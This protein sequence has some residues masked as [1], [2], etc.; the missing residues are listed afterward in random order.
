MLHD[1]K[2]EGDR[3]NLV[4]LQ[5]QDIELIRNWRNKDEIRKWF[6]NDSIISKEAQKNWFA[7][8]SSKEKDYV[9]L[10]EE[11]TGKKI[12]MLAIYNFSNNG[13]MVE[14]GRF[15]IGEEFARGKHY[16]KEAVTLACKLAFEEFGV[17]CVC[18]EV[19]E[20]N[21]AALRTYLSS[22]FKVV[23]EKKHEDRKMLEMELQR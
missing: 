3:L 2:I 11:K 13:K 8:Y 17:E 14:F 15:L 20:D 5:E 4:S 21:N 7:F 10:L 22:G 6:M 19:F 12:G 18:L 9:F 23:G 1:Y 16:G